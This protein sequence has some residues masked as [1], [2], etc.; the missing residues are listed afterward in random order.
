MSVDLFRQP[1]F[2]RPEE[3]LAARR[4]MDQGNIEQAEILRQGIHLETSVRVATLVEP[5]FALIRAVEAKLDA[6]RAHVQG[7][8]GLVLGD[9][10]GAGFIRYPSGGFY[11]PHRD[12]DD[13]A[14]WDGATRRAVAL[15]LF[16]NSSK[17]A[18]PTGEFDGG[19]LR[20]FFEGHDIDVAPQAGLFVAFPATVLHEVTEVR[21]GTRD[22]VVDWFYD[23]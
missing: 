5:E 10:E 23:G 15:V 16:L 17:A 14:G 13:D 9:R 6:C 20:L 18:A 19:L 1:A 8:L 11:R 3:C 22:T 21:D 2:L 12:R 4:G 7:A